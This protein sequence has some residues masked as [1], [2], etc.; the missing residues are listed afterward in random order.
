[1]ATVLQSETTPD[2]RPSPASNTLLAGDSLAAGILFALVLTVGQRAIGFFRSIIFCRLMTDQELGQW[3]IVWGF[4]MLLPPLV[5]LGLP[6]CFGKYS[7]HYLQRG[8]L[9][10]FLIQVTLVAGTTTFAAL[11]ALFLFP[12]FFAGIL[13]SNSSASGLLICL[14]T[15]LIAVSLSNYAASLF[16]S[17]RQVRLV[18]IMRMLIVVA[19]TALGSAAILLFD[20]TVEAVTLAYGLSCLISLIPAVWI[21]CRC[22]DQLI[23]TPQRADGSVRMWRRI[24]PFAGWLWISNLLNNSIEIVDRYM[25][26]TFST[27]PLETA[28]AYVGQYHS[29]RIIPTL[30]SSIAAVLGGILLPY[31]SKLWE[32]G[33]RQGAVLQQNLTLKSVSLI[34]TSGGILILTFA[35]FF[36][37]TVLQGRYNEGMSVFPLTM[38]FYTWFSLYTVGQDYLWVAERGRLVSLSLAIGLIVIVLMN[39]YLI[40]LWGLW[41]AVVASAIGNAVLLT[42]LL[43]M[44]HLT[45]CTL[46]RGLWIMV[47]LPMLMLLPPTTAMF[48]LSLLALLAVRTDWILTLAEKEVVGQFWQEICR[49]FERVF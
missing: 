17:L 8:S 38:V 47:S 44:N 33:K 6:G 37:N 12:S 4:I 7:E 46:D 10:T 2:S 34:F 20:R 48:C 42:T 49:R 14:A 16:E 5:M 21:I 39:V 23:E 40:P 9:R 43:L 31:L 30:L 15:T 35:S 28:Q 29:S 22:R 11:L 26:L 36:F 1:M 27:A 19:F 13:F 45:G 24:L 3:S 32:E 41:G 18:S 25:L